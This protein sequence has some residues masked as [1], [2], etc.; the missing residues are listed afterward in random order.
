MV[1]TDNG[2]MY[3]SP[4]YDVPGFCCGLCIDSSYIAATEAVEY[5]KQYIKIIRKQVHRTRYT[6]PVDFLSVIVKL[7]CFMQER[8]EQ[9][10]R[11]YL[12][13]PRRGGGRHHGKNEAV[14]MDQPSPGTG[15]PE[16]PISTGHPEYMGCSCSAYGFVCCPG[17]VS[18]QEWHKSGG[19]EGKH[20]R[21]ELSYTETADSFSAFLAAESMSLMR[22]SWFTSLA[23]GS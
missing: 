19:I 17:I 2:S 14:R 15:P 20:I 16:E 13:A 11:L 18:E 6:C 1:G 8:A 3:Y 12:D 22:L 21:S 9:I 4:Y 5:I 10:V 23:P 7:L